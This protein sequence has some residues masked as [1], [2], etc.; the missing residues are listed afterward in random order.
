MDE[1]EERGDNQGS[2]EGLQEGLHETRVAL[3][4]PLFLNFRQVHDR[5]VRIRSVR[6]VRVSRVIL[7]NKKAKLSLSVARQE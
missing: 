1:F 6:F 3:P 7:K 5:D 2:P 4:C